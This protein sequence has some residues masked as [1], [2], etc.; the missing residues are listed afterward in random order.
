MYLDVVKLS[1]YLLLVMVRATSHQKKSKEGKKMLQD[2]KKK[3]NWL[4]TQISWPPP[5]L[6]MK[7]GLNES[8][9]EGHYVGRMHR[10]VDRIVIVPVGYDG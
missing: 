10:Y 5:D 8:P 3:K 6:L 7:T 2:K 9:V 1:A 4:H